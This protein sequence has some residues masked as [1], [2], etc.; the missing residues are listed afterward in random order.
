M[1][2]GAGGVTWARVLGPAPR[3]SASLPRS[4]KRVR[5]QPTVSG[6]ST[7]VNVTVRVGGSG[8]G[9]ARSV[10][11]GSL[12]GGRTSLVE[13]NETSVWAVVGG[14]ADVGA[15]LSDQPPGSFVFVLGGVPAAAWEQGT[16]HSTHGATAGAAAGADSNAAPL[17]F[18][19]S[20]HV[21][22]KFGRAVRVHTWRWSK[23]LRGTVVERVPEA[24]E[25]HSLAEHNAASV[26]AL[27]AVI[28][29]KSSA[30]HPPS[31][32]PRRDSMFDGLTDLAEDVGAGTGPFMCVRLGADAFSSLSAAR[33][34]MPRVRAFVAAACRDVAFRH[35]DG[36]TGGPRDGDEPEGDGGGDGVRA[37]ATG[38]GPDTHPPSPSRRR[39]M[40]GN[41]GFGKLPSTSSRTLLSPHHMTAA[42]H[43]YVVAPAAGP[44]VEVALPGHEGESA[45]P[46]ARA[47]CCG[48][49]LCRK[50]GGRGGRGGGDG[51]GGGGGARYG[52]PDVCAAAML[53]TTELRLVVTGLGPVET[54]RVEEALEGL[55]TTR[56]LPDGDGDGVGFVTCAGDGAAAYKAF[57]EAFLEQHGIEWM[58]GG[59]TPSSHHLELRS[60]K[61]PTSSSR[62]GSRRLASTP[63]NGSG[64][65]AVAV[66]EWWATRGAWRLLTA[67]NAPS[68]VEA[69]QADTAEVGVVVAVAVLFVACSASACIVIV[70][71]TVVC[72][73]AR[74]CLCGCGLR[75]PR[76]RCWSVGGVARKPSRPSHSL[77]GCPGLLGVPWIACF[78]SRRPSRSAR[79]CAMP[80]CSTPMKMCVLRA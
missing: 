16:R 40:A 73:C 28:R 45:V 79:W 9:G 55:T 17:R 10:S 30:L 60:P 31:F 38:L 36:T 75:L 66:T 29:G 56:E 35:G 69:L 44:G 52:T 8:R 4:S 24:M 50:L 12:P 67:D 13:P 41:R 78:A 11:A 47:A 62:F 57:R 1:G 20:L 59:D 39:G 26:R 27:E 3:P 15:V 65:L 33:D 72:L 6:S 48:S 61:H 76:N 68:L 23:S 80:C 22:F 37:V 58:R 53:S 77:R 54:K 21:A 32:T 14:V 19:G 71:P 74:V 34:Y 2:G 7:S 63:N 46:P 51:G 70:R 18:R 5:S 25:G 43:G 42:R 49:W 64:I